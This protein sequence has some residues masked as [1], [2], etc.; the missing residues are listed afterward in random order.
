MM[1]VFLAVK[2]FC[3]ILK[4]QKVLVKTDNTT[5]MTYINKQGGTHSPSLCILVWN[6][7]QWAIDNKVILTSQHIAGK[8]NI[9]A[10]LLS[11][12]SKILPA[13]WML[14]RSVVETIF[15]TWDRP[16]VDLFATRWNCQIQTFV[17]PFPDELA[18][19]VDA[20]SLSWQGI[21]GYAYPPVVLIPKIL[22]KIQS[23]NCI[24][25]LIAPFW[26]RQSWFPE[27]AQLLIDYPVRLPVL[28]NLI[29]QQ[30]G[31]ILHPNVE[32]LKLTAWKL[33][34]NSS[35]RRGFLNQC[36]KEQHLV[37]EVVQTRHTITDSD[38]ILTGPREKILIPC[39]H[40]NLR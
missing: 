21:M 38:F 36:L 14:D 9:L 7:F 25:I 1:A 35:L 4:G 32:M 18:Y 19:S 6:M 11:R 34:A 40:L 17:S 13:E 30:K 29:S 33:S 12:R 2:H 20:L 31:K 5:V 23:S 15:N 8:A 3:E 27:L 22:Q 24:I 37:D 28:H 26:T 16:Q 10:D 39:K